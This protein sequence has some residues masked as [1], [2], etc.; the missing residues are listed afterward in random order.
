MYLYF[1]I[2]LHVHS[3]TCKIRFMFHVYILTGVGHTIIHMEEVSTYM[4]NSS[5]CK[6]KLF[7][8]MQECLTSVLHT[9][10]VMLYTHKG[11]HNSQNM[12]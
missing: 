6:N 12:F 5:P 4:Y 10:L 2:Q 9:V 8:D 3:V 1:S 7:N 11:F